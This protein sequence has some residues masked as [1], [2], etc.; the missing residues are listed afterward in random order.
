M[1]RNRKIKTKSNFIGYNIRKRKKKEKATELWFARYG[2]CREKQ[3]Q[4][5]QENFRID[6]KFMYT[7]VFF[8]MNNNLVI[9]VLVAMLEQRK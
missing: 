3:L 8:L 2:V 6:R 1:K 7:G 9:S 5:I 4:G